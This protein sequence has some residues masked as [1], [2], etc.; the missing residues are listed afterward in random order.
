[1]LL[2]VQPIVTEFRHTDVLTNRCVCRDDTLFVAEN[3]MK[4]A[5]FTRK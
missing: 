4:Y 2:Q 1:L 5:A 3:Q